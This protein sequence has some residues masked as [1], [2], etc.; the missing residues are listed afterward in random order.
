LSEA[1]QAASSSPSAS[2]FSEAS[3]RADQN[4]PAGC[5]GPEIVMDMGRSP[6]GFKA[7][8]GEKTL[9]FAGS[10]RAIRGP[11]LANHGNGS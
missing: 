10:N 5:L 6:C 1:F 4:D 3:R 11:I 2:Q 7:S 9:V 8:V